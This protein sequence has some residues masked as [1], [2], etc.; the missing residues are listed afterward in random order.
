MGTFGLVERMIPPVFVDYVCIIRC[1]GGCHLSPVRLLP[2]MCRAQKWAQFSASASKALY[3]S[4][5]RLTEDITSLKSTT[6]TSI[7]EVLLSLCARLCDCKGSASRL[8]LTT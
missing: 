8:L 2:G 5:L 7:R 6:C 1:A 4:T 3:L